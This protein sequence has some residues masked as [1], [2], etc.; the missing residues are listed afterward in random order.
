M[1]RIHV[2]SLERMPR[3]VREVE[4]TRVLTVMKNVEQ[5]A[6]PPR[7]ADGQHLKL[8][9]SDIIA[10]RPGETLADET[11]IEELL[12]FGESWD[13]TAPLVVHCYAGVSRSTASAFIIACLLRP[14]VSEADWARAIRES[15]PTATPNIHL[16][17]LADELLARRG[18]MVA[19]IEAIGRGEDCFEGVPF[20]L[21]IGPG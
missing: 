6:T 15:S 7:I 14:D 3:M 20:A 16:V 19:A 4:A 5:V 18:R 17:R 2:C 9:F 12:A 10:P 8:E 21:E 1:P 13:R 11:H